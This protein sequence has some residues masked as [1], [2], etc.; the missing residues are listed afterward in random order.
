MKHVVTVLYEDSAIDDRDFPLHRLVVRCV[1]DSVLERSVAADFG[2]LV[3]DGIRGIPRNSNSKVRAACLRD[4]RDLT[5]DGNHVVALYDSDRVHDLV[6]TSGRCKRELTTSLREGCSPADRLRVVLLE[7]NTE[8]LITALRRG[9]VEELVGKG[10]FDRAL[11]KDRN[12]R[13]IALKAAA[14]EDFRSV[15][16]ALRQ[17]VPSL[18]YLTTKLV[19]LVLREL[20]SDAP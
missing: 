5:A 3:R 14:R 2:A 18:D 17:T 12:A 15:R 20:T 7:R 16:T 1:H 4:L 6:P 9:P 11:K 19:G 10:V 13:D 8:S